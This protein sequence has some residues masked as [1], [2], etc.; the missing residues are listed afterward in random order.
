MQ[1]IVLLILHSKTKNPFQS[2]ASETALTFTSFTLLLL[3]LLFVNLGTDDERQ[4]WKINQ[5]TH[6]L[7]YVTGD[8]G[9]L[10]D[11]ECGEKFQ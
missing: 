7:P 4:F 9:C 6:C 3:L 11:H 8:L 10:W 5:D 2:I 1:L